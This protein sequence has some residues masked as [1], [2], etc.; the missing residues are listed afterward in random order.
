MA[1]AKYE[2]SNQPSASQVG[3]VTVASSTIYYTIILRFHVGYT[4]GYNV[5]YSVIPL[6]TFSNAGNT[7]QRCNGVVKIKFRCV[8]L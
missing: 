2:A 8:H 5:F 1:T 3:D 6:T 7:S 4:V